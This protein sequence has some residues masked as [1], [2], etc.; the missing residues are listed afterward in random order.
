LTPGE[1][2]R[3]LGSYELG[4]V[5][6]VRPF[7]AGSSRAPK[8]RVETDTGTYLLKRLAPN[9]SAPESVRFQHRLIQH[10]TASG[11]PVAEV[12]RTRDSV[13]V[14][15]EGDARYELIRWIDGH[16]YEYVPREAK[17]AGAAMAGMHE[18]AAGMVDEAPIGRG[19]HNRRDVARA[20]LELMEKSDADVVK[21]LRRIAS[22]LQAARRNVREVWPTLPETVVHGDWHPGNLLMGEDRVSGV[23][24][25]ESARFEPRVT[26]FANGLLQFSLERRPGTPP[27]EWPVPCD[28]A[29][30]GSMNAG[31]QLL[32]RTPI[33]STEVEVVPDLMIEAMAVESTITIIRKGRIRQM[34]PASVIP[35]IA[36]RLTWIDQSRD[37]LA[38]AITPRPFVGD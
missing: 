23:I 26:D 25:F 2:A 37:A 22:L 5:E 14:V 12:I 35:W 36:D 8:A 27:T 19:Y 21:G 13:T 38:T 30:V 9:R 3:V 7:L 16:R 4:D 15:A 17:A 24:D 6:S 11:Y 33:S 32:A 20:L 29:L 1:I 10:L 34:D 28:L 18:L 31:Y